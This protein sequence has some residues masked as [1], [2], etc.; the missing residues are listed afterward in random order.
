M[1]PHLK[2]YRYLPVTL[3]HF[4][5]IKALMV[6]I[7]LQFATANDKTQ[8]TRFEGFE[9]GKISAKCSGNCPIISQEIVKSGKYSMKVSLD[10]NLSKVNYRTEI[11]EVKKA[12]F[13]EDYWYEF[14]VYLPKTYISDDIWE[15][16]AQWHAVP[17]FHLGEDW[18]NPVLSLH[19]TNGVWGIKSVWDSKKNTFE[20]GKIEYSGSK[21][22]ALGNYET[23]Q[24]IT[25]KFHVIWSHLDDGLIEVWK[26]GKQ[27]I[28]KKGPNCFNDDIGPY[29]KMGMYKG[30]KTSQ[31][32]SKTSKRVLYFD[33]ISI[34]N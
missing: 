12:T 6:T 11:T 25:W 15:S 14:S 8:T 31:K 7:S 10:I 3:K 4:I 22:W 28:S 2:L 16:I 20:S 18:R 24:W 13:G 5:L 23:N 19:T 27:V 9:S 26:N 17:D 1:L 33:D 30:W 21:M 32:P 34:T 29:F